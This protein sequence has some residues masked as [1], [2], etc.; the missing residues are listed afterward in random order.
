MTQTLAQL[1]PANI[2][3]VML[4]FCRTGSALMLLPGF[5]DLY[6]PQRYRLILALLLAALVATALGTHLPAAPGNVEGL[7]RLVGGEILIGLFLGTIGR[8][9]LGALD[10]AGMIVSFQLG[11]SAAQIFNPAAAQQGA[12][13]GAFM[14]VLGVLII[15]LTNTHHLLLRALVGSYDLFAPGGF[16]IIGDL[17][18]TV[19]HVV[20]AS[21]RLAV[22]L[23]APVIVLGTVFFVAM[24]LLS[25]LMPQLQIFFV[26]LPIQ[27]VGGLLVFGLTLYAVMSWFLGGFTE[28]FGQALPL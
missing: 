27:I 1:L 15:F 4:V 18:D 16:P 2:F 6:V 14:T 19:A 5:G 10:T 13:T 12:I 8:I 3:A 26:I 11:L 20:A 7:A 23:S 21:F 24:G 9:I 17:S 22:E 25:R 28:I